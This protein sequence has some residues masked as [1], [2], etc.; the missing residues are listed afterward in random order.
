MVDKPRWWKKL[1]AS[2]LWSMTTIFAWELVEEALENLIAYGISSVVA[3]FITKA[4]STLA[5]ITA[6]QGLK[7]GIKRF[8]FP[9]IKTLIYKEG[10]DKMNLV[11]NYFTKAWG[12]KL[13]GLFSA[14][15]ASL[16]TY[17]Q[18]IVPFAT[19]CWWIALLVGVIFFNLAIFFGGETIKQI[20]A[21]FAEEHLTKEQKKELKKIEHA[22]K[23][24]K[25]Y[26]ESVKILAQKQNQQ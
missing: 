16:C 7:V 2:G 24:V 25:E 19:G 8:V 23:V 12:N 1:M 13:T 21:R 14:I 5:I 17:W 15:P 9:Y 26:E 11:N 20:I 18:T 4:L 3:L 22:E 6:T 10:N